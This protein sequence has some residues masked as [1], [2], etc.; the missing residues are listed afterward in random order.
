[1]KL[2]HLRVEI[3]LAR[4]RIRAQRSD[5]RKLQQAGISTKSAEELL[6]RMQ[7]R[8]DDLCEQRDKLKGEQRLSRV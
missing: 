2:E 6:A 4:G 5:I 8:V 3:E 7:A 1:M